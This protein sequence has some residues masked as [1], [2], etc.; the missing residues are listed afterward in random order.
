MDLEFDSEMLDEFVSESRDHMATIEEDFLTL[1][2][3]KDNPDS[4][5]VNKVFRAIHT[6]KGCAGFL[7]MTNINELAH[8]M[9]TLLSMVRNGEI[10]P[11]LRFVD[12][13][14]EGVDKLNSLLDN[15]EKSNEID[16]SVIHRKLSELLTNGPPDSVKEEI[17][18]NKPLAGFDG[19]DIGFDISAF[20]FKNIPDNPFLYVLKYDLIKFMQSGNKS[21]V[22]LIKKLLSLGDIVDARIETTSDDLYIGLPVGP[23]LYEVLFSTDIN[24]E[25]I[26]SSVELD[27]DSIEQ[28]NVN[29]IPTI[30]ESEKPAEVVE[31]QR[32][33]VKQVEQR[34]VVV[35]KEEKS[36][37]KEE[38]LAEQTV[39]EKNR[40]EI[41][42]T[43]DNSGD[44]NKST[45]VKAAGVERGGG[46]IRINVDILEELM[47]LAG[48][49]VLVRNQQLINV[50][51]SDPVARSITQ[52]LDIVT[53]ELQESI[54]RTRMQPIGNVLNK[55]TRIVRDLGNKLGK[56]ISI[57]ITGAEV[58]LDKT[59]LESLADPLTHLVRNCCDH[60]IETIA[61]RKANGKSENGCI[62]LKAYHEGGQVNIEINDDG[63]GINVSAIKKKVLE[64]GLK[65]DTEVAQMSEK[66]IMTLILLPGFS[67]AETVS[68]ISG[69]GVGMDVVKSNIES[70]GGTIDIDSVEGKG[71]KMHLRL[72]LTLA[73]IPCLIV[74]V[75][76]Y[77]YAIP[78]INLVEL[79]CLYDEDVKTKIES[80]GCNEV[81]RL[82]DTLLPMVRL[83]EVLNRQ[84]TFTDEIRSEITE[85]YRY[86]QNGNHEEH[87]CDDQ[88]HKS[89]NFTVL[90]VG[91]RR[92][93]LIVDKVLGTEEIVVK[94][95]H[96]AL[97][98]LSVYSGATVMGDGKVALILDVDGLSRHVGIEDNG[99]AKDLTGEGDGF[100]EN[101]KHAVLLF[102]NGEKEQFAVPLPLIRRIEH[103]NTDNVE[104]IGNK[105][106]ITIDGVSTLVIKL[107]ELLQVSKCVENKEMYLLLPKHINKPFGILISNLINVVDTSMVLNEDSYME[108]GLQ[109]SSIVN[110]N[111]TLFVDIY[112]IIEKAE[113]AWFEKQNDENA[114][115]ASAG[116]RILLL[117]DTPF[118]RQLIQGY[119]IDEG[120][121]VIT[122]E[123]GQIGLT[124]FNENDF[125]LIISDI[126]MPVMDGVTFLKN[127]RKG[128]RNNNIPA[129]AVTAL[130]SESDK[131][132]VMESGFDL[133][134]TKF[135]RE[136]FLTSVNSML[137]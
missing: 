84:S 122:A 89:L 28:V 47:M 99:R 102:K 72:P 1:E 90:K 45:L 38:R 133:Y 130:D 20:T 46:T 14:L 82:R 78:Q 107:D 8:V 95:M 27:E 6:I 44:E 24:P 65:S 94:P 17:E 125:D 74:M 35:K 18:T 109:G 86:K 81:Y 75:G 111:L 61:D 2:K 120:F 101:D 113:P 117:E 21:P 4:E 124:C 29:D 10:K 115:N 112:G 121:D 41:A 91:N 108:K 69:R 132:I 100:T 50:D 96:P 53:S 70:L 66:E 110:E 58:E 55:F 60:G 12:P 118:F 56:K 97:K 80:A 68:E 52:R 106:Y 3:Q 129:I 123:N 134:E 103:I 32:E 5:L 135:N 7:G 13:L 37:T 87:N 71:T 31:V 85:K 67:T 36:E 73:I 51:K 16:I 39:Q 92:F 119:L 79:M 83:A 131:R 11:E 57:E 136:S 77:R 40:V 59:I 48:E 105:S 9:E 42:S 76:D 116:K 126:E 23:L 19:E 63:K 43:V 34:E 64:K 88:E 128:N 49:L 114:H 104:N 30:Q 15:V 93:G 22:K 33:V 98:N 137:N 26:S 62:E 54:M 25:N 127:V